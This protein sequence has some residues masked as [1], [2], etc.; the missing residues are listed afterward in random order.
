MGVLDTEQPDWAH[1]AA[2]ELILLP[3]FGLE[4]G[5]A[6]KLL[7]RL[8]WLLLEDGVRFFAVDDKHEIGEENW[9]RPVEKP[10]DAQIHL[11]ASAFPNGPKLVQVSPDLLQ[12]FR[13]DPGP[14]RLVPNCRYQ[15][16]SLHPGPDPSPM[17][18]SAPVLTVEVVDAT[19]GKAVPGAGVELFEDVP[20]AIG[21]LGTSDSA[22]RI[23][24]KV[25]GVPLK[26]ERLYVTPP[27]T[28]YWGRFAE[29]IV[30]T[31]SPYQ[32]ALDPVAAA[33][34]DAARRVYPSVDT[35]GAGVRV[36]VVDHG[37]D[38][39]EVP[40]A[41]GCNL[42]LG[43]PDG[44]HGDD[45]TGHGTHVA[46][47]IA[48]KQAGAPGGIAPAAEIFSYRVFG[49]GMDATSFSVLMAV[50]AAA[51]DDC[52]LINLSV[53][54]L[55]HDAILRDLD[56]WAADHGSVLF[57]ATGNDWGGNVTIP[58]A[59]HSTLA[60]AAVGRVG[61]FPA[62]SLEDAYIGTRSTTDNDDFFA[63][64]ANYLPNRAV[65]LIAPGVGILSVREGGGYGPLSGTS[66]ACAVAT[67]AA[68]R[69]LT[70]ASWLTDA[71]DL[72]RSA[73]MKNHLIPNTQRIGLP[74]DLEG[75]GLLP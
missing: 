51:G 49:V 47:I 25:A 61:T 34:V 16:V 6:E 46:G 66:Q 7:Y 70:N 20:H 22:G 65:D 36:G 55:A 19:S 21:D 24:L 18:G 32:V 29:N 53:G 45:G 15:T 74:L 38:A 52:H 31:S 12:R 8:H 57:A 26:V 39:G 75:S 3:S 40:V 60:V 9:L 59:L 5:P 13:T 41:G 73:A 63:S 10:D 43:E 17:P 72:A 67:G 54:G 33:H 56:I 28:G 2:T 71:A 58:A 48:N 27:G 23:D 50:V 64:F 14:L 35:N 42:V 30:I 1:Y 69:A 4:G 37:I 44:D 11:L 62:G 68:A